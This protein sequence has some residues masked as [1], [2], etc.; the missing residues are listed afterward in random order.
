MI[1]EYERMIMEDME[2]EQAAVERARA[3]GR[4]VR[5]S[6]RS[7]SRIAF[8]WTNSPDQEPAPRTLAPVAELR[9]EI[10]DARRINRTNDWRWALFVD[11]RRAA[12][13]YGWG[14]AGA[15]GAEALLEQIEM[16]HPFDLD[17]VVV[18]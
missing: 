3:E 18:A 17:V 14:Y 8:S 9:R 11:G 15:A 2:R 5:V 16:G 10:T 12:R 6:S 1:D 7:R 4:V 13:G